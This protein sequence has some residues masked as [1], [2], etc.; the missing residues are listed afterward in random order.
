MLISLKNKN[1]VFVIEEVN[2]YQQKHGGDNGGGG[3]GE[4]TYEIHVAHDRV[5]DRL[6]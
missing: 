4:R 5:H 3:F 1:E 2:T 6:L